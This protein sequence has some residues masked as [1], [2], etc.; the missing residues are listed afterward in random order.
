MLTVINHSFKF[1]CISSIS[2]IM[3]K[4]LYICV[5]CFI[6]IIG[7]CPFTR[8]KSIFIKVS[9]LGMSYNVLISILYSGA[10]VKAIKYRNSIRLSQETP[11]AVIIDSFSQTLSYLTIVSSWLVCAACRQQTLLRV[12]Q[13]FKNV[14]NLE[15]DLLT[16]PGSIKTGIEENFKESRT[17]F[18]IVNLACIIFTGSSVAIVSMC[19]D[20]QNQSWFWFTYNI[21]INVI[22][23]VAF[24]LSQFMSCLRKHYEILNREAFTLVRSRKRSFTRIAFLEKVNLSIPSYTYNKIS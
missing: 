16:I 5:Y 13:S 1:A 23:N 15:R 6:K 24:I 19:Q 12:L 20:M 10:F 3:K 17:R 7:L 11:L 18:I 14:E 4:I 21:P 8:D 22:F 2:I 9:Y